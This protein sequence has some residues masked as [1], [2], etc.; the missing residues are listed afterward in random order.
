MFRYDVRIFKALRQEIL[1][2]L[3]SLRK[4]IHPDIVFLPSSS[5]LHQDHSTIYAE[6]I[7]AFKFNSILGYEMPWNNMIFATSSFIFLNFSILMI[8]Q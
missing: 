1:Q 2:D 5:D 8:N 7:R 3:I 6:G 4:L